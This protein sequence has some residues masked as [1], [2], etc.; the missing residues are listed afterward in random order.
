MC[1][2]LLE[3]LCLR[4]FYVLVTLYNPVG[5]W[6]AACFSSPPLR[7]LSST[8]RQPASR[9]RFQ[10]V[11]PR[12]RYHHYEAVFDQDSRSWLWSYLEPNSMHI[13]SNPPRPHLPGR[14]TMTPSLV[15]SYPAKLSCLGSGQPGKP[16]PCPART[17]TS[18]YPSTT[19]SRIAGTTIWS[20]SM[21]HNLPSSTSTPDWA[22]LTHC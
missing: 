12:V 21:D 4:C 9:Y 5:R 1:W 8:L 16:T 18:R 14:P 6:V 20:T 7:A 2:T 22:A 3:N 13:F 11:D 15:I 19:D 10:E 17:T